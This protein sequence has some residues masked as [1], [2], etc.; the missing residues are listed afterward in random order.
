MADDLSNSYLGSYRLI[1]IIG[2]GSR[3][4]VYKAFQPSLE[5]FVAIKVLHKRDPQFTE[6]FER[7]AHDRHLLNGSQARR[8]LDT[9]RSL[10][11]EFGLPRHAATRNKHCR[12]RNNAF[13]EHKYGTHESDGVG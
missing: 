13:F 12:D 1:E 4:V 3:A 10:W 6:R 8:Y 2:R 11:Y 5:R 9:C 7:E